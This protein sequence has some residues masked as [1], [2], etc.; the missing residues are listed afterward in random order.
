[1]FARIVPVRA[2]RLPG[3][4]EDSHAMTTPASLDPAP[5]QLTLAAIGISALV[6]VLGLAI[7]FF[8]YGPGWSIASPRNTT[9]AE[10]SG[11]GDQITSEFRVREDWRIEWETSGP[12]FAMA[13]TGDQDLGTVV[14]ADGADSGLTAPPIPGVFQI[15][16]RASGP[17]TVK[18]LQGR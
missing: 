8:S 15:E 9:V 5:R 14:T 1:M 2:V 7:S 6:L 3:D 10:F 17:W 18:V 13:I 4:A 11:D 12:A 16:I